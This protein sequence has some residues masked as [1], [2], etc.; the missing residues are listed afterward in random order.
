M[1]VTDAWEFDRGS[2]A[3]VAVIDGGI[4]LNHPD[5]AGQLLPG[6]DY[7]NLDLEPM[8]GDGHG[9]H[10]AGTI[11]ARRG[12]TFG[13][14]GVAP[15]AK[16]LPIQVCGA[17]QG[18][19][20]A[21]I[22]AGIIY[23]ADNGVDVINLSIGGAT[24]VQVEADAVAYAQALDVL[25]VAAA[26]NTGLNQPEYPASYAGVLGVGALTP[27]S[28]VATFSNRGEHVDVVAPG[29]EILSTKLGGTWEMLDG[30]SMAA[31]HVS[32]VAALLR[33]ANPSMTATQAAARLMS[34]A[35]D[36]GVS[37]RDDEFGFGLVNAH[38]ALTNGQNVDTDYIEL[39]I[40]HGWFRDLHV[41]VIHDGV[42]RDLF[43][44]TFN[45]SDEDNILIR[46]SLPPES[47][48]AVPGD[49]RLEVAD[50]YPGGAGTVQSFQVRSGGV[51]YGALTPTAI[52]DGTGQ[53]IGISGTIPNADA[54]LAALSVNPGS[55]TPGFGAAT[56]NYN[57]AVPAGQTSIDVTATTADPDASLVIEGSGATSGATTPVALTGSTT[58]V[59]IVV[60][61]EDGVA[62]QIYEIA[63]EQA[64][65]ANAE[66]T[67]VSISPSTG[68]IIHDEPTL[69]TAK[70][71]DA[72]GWSNLR[73]AELKV[74][75]GGSAPVCA[76][77]Y[78]D[79][80]GTFQLYDDG[81]SDAGA[82]GS[83]GIAS[84]D[85]CALDPTQSAVAGSGSQ[86]T[87]EF[88]LEFSPSFLGRHGLRLWAQDD[89]RTESSHDKRGSIIVEEPPQPP[90]TVSVT[91]DAATIEVGTQVVISA[92][93]E[94]GNGW[95]NLRYGE[96]RVNATNS[97]PF[98][99]LQYNQNEN[100]FRLREGDIWVDAGQ[101]GSGGVTANA[102]CAFD[103]SA[104]SVGGNGD[105][106]TVSFAITFTA[107]FAG[108]HGL[109]LK[110]KDDSA[111]HTPLTKHGFVLV[112]PAP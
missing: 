41:R 42:T 112:V 17:G 108:R 56:L 83:G 23:A 27:G 100:R 68:R 8:D 13:G 45:A 28:G 99:R 32:G 110:A 79:D 73:F 16:L 39:Y 72:D 52:P 21:A 89:P 50:F 51:I 69:F 84:N 77:R 86:L 98:C 2:G 54:E 70:F 93:Y 58:V 40:E 105:T 20:T 1:D 81:W 14:T 19:S 97:S 24:P 6:I 66:P 78:N 55:L 18:C 62:R 25:V 11:A 31:P 103:A 57:V 33:A 38:R 109:R 53:Y 90:A 3:T 48:Q 75:A 101:P 12:D 36:L 26:G 9:T 76:V 74:T 10:V 65:P 63:V 29:V 15:E 59:E 7:F 92:S 61:A 34:S 80:R 104:S 95:Q 37:G 46:Y 60:T 87:V 111:T 43:F 82:P 85:N 47:L 5:F 30:T 4:D 102:E 64:A 44:P 67:T 35:I 91:P 88:S 71:D 49:W 22:A 106:L 94:D 96:L 107:E